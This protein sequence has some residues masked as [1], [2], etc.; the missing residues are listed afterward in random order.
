MG[1]ETDQG[2]EMVKCGVN[3]IN[4]VFEKVKECVGEGEGTC[5]GI[6]EVSLTDF[7]EE[8]YSGLSRVCED[9]R[10]IRLQDWTKMRI[11]L[12]K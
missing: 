9:W 7:D 11:W 8:L 4:F 3:A 5:M 10:L 1:K 2:N 6:L 12:W